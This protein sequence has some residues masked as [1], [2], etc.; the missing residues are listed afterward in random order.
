MGVHA[1]SPLMV[2]WHAADA[3][4]FGMPPL[5]D[6][7]DVIATFQNVGFDVSVARL[8]MR[9]VPAVGHSHEHRGRM[10]DWLAYYHDQK[11]L[12]RFER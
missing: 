5:Y 4:E 3:E 2:E 11:L 8:N 7:D 9:F 6:V 10:L 1:G 12:F